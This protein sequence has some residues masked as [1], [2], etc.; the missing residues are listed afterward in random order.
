MDVGLEEQL[1]VRLG[2]GEEGL[3]GEEELGTDG[4]R[5]AQRRKRKDGHRQKNTEA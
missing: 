3:G 1:D 4:F 5:L 2:V